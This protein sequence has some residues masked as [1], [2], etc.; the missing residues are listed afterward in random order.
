MKKKIYDID[1]FLIDTPMEKESLLEEIKLT[2]ESLIKI[3]NEFMQIENPLPFEERASLIREFNGESVYM[4]VLLIFLENKIKVVS[5]N[6]LPEKFKRILRESN[7]FNFINYFNNISTINDFFI[8]VD[9][10]KTFLT[11]F[12]KFEEIE[13]NFKK[14]ND[15]INNIK[16]V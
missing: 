5:F 9:L 8:P 13:F 4:N 15:N 6:D 12:N 14:A 10:L 1:Y 7:F 11:L 3:V 2:K 16:P